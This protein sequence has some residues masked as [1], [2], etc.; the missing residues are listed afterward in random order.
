MNVTSWVSCATICGKPQ[1][2]RSKAR[3]TQ[4]RRRP[5][6][7]QAP[8]AA[9]TPWLWQSYQA[10][11]DIAFQRNASLSPALLGCNALSGL[12]TRC[13]N[14]GLQPIGPEISISR[15]CTLTGRCGPTLSRF[16]PSML[17]TF[18]FVQLVAR[19]Y[20]LDGEIGSLIGEVAVLFEVW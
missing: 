2:P 3:F 8:H 6:K 9:R 1:T 12:C 4:R 10:H 5:I 17:M 18:F 16:L 13:A 14:C 19:E 11:H 20:L 7:S 15:S